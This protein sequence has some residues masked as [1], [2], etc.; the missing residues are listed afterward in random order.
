MIGIRI[1]PVMEPS[2]FVRGNAIVD[3]L[4]QR[5]SVIYLAERCKNMVSTL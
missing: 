2:E 3:D 5:L 1:E 4:P